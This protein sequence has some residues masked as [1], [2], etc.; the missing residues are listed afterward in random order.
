M[1]RPDLTT[2]LI[3]FVYFIAGASSLAGVATTFFYKDDLGLTLEQL[4]IL[5]SVAII[6]WSIKPIYGIIS[7]RVPLRGLRRK[8]YLILSGFLGSL[9][10]LSLATWVEGFWGV[11]V[12]ELISALGFAMADVIVDGVVA[13]RSKTHKAAGKLQSICRAAIMT[14]ALVVAYSSGVL[15]ESIGARRVFLL[16][17]MLPLFTSLIAIFLKELPVGMTVWDW[18]QTWANFKKALQPAILWSALFLFIWR[19]TPT[20][21]GAFSY[22]LIDELHFDPEFFG[23]LAVISRFMGIAGVLIFRKW[24]IAIPL[25]RLLLGIVIASIILSMPSLGLVYGWY[26]LLGVSPKFFAMADTLISA[27]L[28]EIGFLPLLVLVARVCPKGIEATVFAVL[29]SIM[30]IGLAISDMGG[31]ALVHFFD[32][33]QATE[34]LAANYDNLD[35]VLWIAI[36]SSVLPLP[37]L[38]FL[39]ETRAEEEIE[40]VGIP[41][42]IEPGI[43]GTTIA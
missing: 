35:K 43:G 2:L 28:S 6:P 22:Y 1:K 30:N 15:T 41:S 24:L 19:S 17:A 31:A 40:D 12:A 29:A 7:D 26:T 20:S 42:G 16:T 27:P 10:Y 9:G 25:K 39:P 36:L 21:G 34:T 38:P 37:L 32:V 5:S 33:H 3:P 11:L 14:G 23:T 8:P 18:R 13:E 4:G